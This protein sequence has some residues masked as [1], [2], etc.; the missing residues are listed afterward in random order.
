MMQVIDRWVCGV[1]AGGD[2]IS[3]RAPVTWALSRCGGWSSVWRAEEYGT[4]SKFV[5]L[6]G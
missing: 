2:M 6:P 1:Y 4:F 3:F 5:K